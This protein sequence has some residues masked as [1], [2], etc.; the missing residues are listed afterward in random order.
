MKKQLLFMV[1][2]LLIFAGFSPM[3]TYVLA[4]TKLDDVIDT[5]L[6]NLELEKVDEVLSYYKNLETE[7]I[8]QNLK[9][10]IE[11]VINGKLSFDYMSIIQILTAIITEK[12]KQFIPIFVTIAG[13]GIMLSL[14]KEFNLSN[15]KDIE[16]ILH[17]A[18]MGIVVIIISVQ[19]TSLI[20]I[21]KASIT[22]INGKM[23]AIFP[24][25]IIT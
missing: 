13:L 3:N 22:G 19:V 23:Q 9:S 24:I 1:I 15:R 10:Y 4:E 12:L 17:I 18:F 25:L 14:F 8:G 6:N 2:I 5:Q 20:N 11:D 16:Q 7:L 21:T